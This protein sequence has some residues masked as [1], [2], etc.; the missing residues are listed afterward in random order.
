MN[1]VEATETLKRR[2]FR[3]CSKPQE[4]RKRGREKQTEGRGG[5]KEGGKGARERGHISERAVF[6][7]AFG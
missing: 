5:D 1:A 7:E 6:V 2:R 4:G 3:R